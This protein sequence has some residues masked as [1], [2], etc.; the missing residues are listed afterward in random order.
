MRE[1]SH[2]SPLF[3]II[4]QFPPKMGT[5]YMALIRTSFYRASSR[6]TTPI[7]RILKILDFYSHKG[8]VT[9]RINHCQVHWAGLKVP[10]TVK[11][12]QAFNIQFSFMG[13]KLGIK[14]AAYDYVMNYACYTLTSSLGTQVFITLFGTCERKEGSAAAANGVGWCL[15]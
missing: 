5:K 7:H 12:I 4:L 14:G 15:R 9:F 6:P 13:P 10:T 8:A 11:S 2:T 1:W 3:C